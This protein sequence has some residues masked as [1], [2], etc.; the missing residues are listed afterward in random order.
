[1]EKELFCKSSPGIDELKELHSTH[2]ESNPGDSI[3][4]QMVIESEGHGFY[5]SF[6]DM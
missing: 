6:Y 3:A 4:L 5:I 2:L 1:M